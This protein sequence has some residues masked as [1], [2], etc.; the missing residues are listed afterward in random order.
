MK[1]LEKIKIKVRG[2]IDLQQLKKDGLIVGKNF[3]AMQGVIIDPGHCWLIEIG[4]NVTLAPNVHILAH[5]ASMKKS[6]GYAK[7]GQVII[8]NNVFIGAGSIILPNVVIADNTIVGAGS[9]VTASLLDS[10]VYVGNPAKKI[11]SYENWFDKQQQNIKTLPVFDE[12]YKIGNISD[13]KKA[14]MKKKLKES[15]GYIV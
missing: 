15:I 2:S 7:I 3:N 4:D 14:E 10:G 11:C 1:L 6:L 9:V 8:G 12:S 13:Q 5:D